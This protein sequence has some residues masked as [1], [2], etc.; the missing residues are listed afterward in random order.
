MATTPSNI[1]LPN[2]SGYYRKLKKN[3]KFVKIFIFL[4]Y[5]EI[6]TFIS[7]QVSGISNIKD[8]DVLRSFFHPM[9]TTEFFYFILNCKCSLM[10]RQNSRKEKGAGH[11]IIKVKTREA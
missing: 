6:S 1:W 11:E 8:G 9:K 3:N 10:R 2:I 5:T 7:L 4:N